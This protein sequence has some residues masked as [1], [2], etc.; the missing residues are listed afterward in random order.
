M[1]GVLVSVRDL[2]SWLVI[3]S[4][5]VVLG[6]ILSAFTSMILL[7]PLSIPIK[8]GQTGTAL[9]CWQMRKSRHLEFVT[10]PD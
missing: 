3:F 6:G 5:V 4:G 10:S 1:I 2:L 7:N 8:V 9:C